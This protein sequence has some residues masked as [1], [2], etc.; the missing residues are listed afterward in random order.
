MARIRRKSEVLR[1]HLVIHRGSRLIA[2]KDLI[3]NL[4]NILIRT[5]IEPRH[6]HRVLIRQM[7]GLSVDASTSSQKG[8]PHM[9]ITVA[10]EG[11]VAVLVLWIGV[12]LRCVGRQS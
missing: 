3:L 8:R 7:G 2:R 11:T 5:A 9:D 6:M 12:L 4:P 1:S 10:E